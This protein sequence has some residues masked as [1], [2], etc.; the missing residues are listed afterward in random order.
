MP[1]LKGRK[2]CGLVIDDILFY[3]SF[4]CFRDMTKE[5]AMCDGLE[6]KDTV[7]GGFFLAREGF[8]EK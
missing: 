3:Y 6:I 4:L 5:T 7:S 8:V 1:V 2:F